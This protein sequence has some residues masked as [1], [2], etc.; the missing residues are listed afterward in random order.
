[1][2]QTLGGYKIF[3]SNEDTT[4]SD[5][6]IDKSLILHR[7]T[8]ADADYERYTA[9]GYFKDGEFIWIP[10]CCGDGGSGQ[11]C[12]ISVSGIASGQAT[13]G[14]NDVNLRVFVNGLKGAPTFTINGVQVSP[15]STSGNE[16]IFEG[17]GQG[18][19]TVIVTDL[20]ITEYTCTG[21]TIIN[22]T[23]EV[24]RCDGF[25]LTLT[26][27]NAGGEA[28]PVECGLTGLRVVSVNDE[29]DPIAYGTATGQ[30]LLDVE[31]TWTGPLLFTINGSASIQPTP[32]SAGSSI[33][34]YSNLEAGEYTVFV[35]DTAVPNSQCLQSVYFEIVE[36]EDPCDGFNLTLTKQDSGAYPDLTCD[37]FNV[38]LTKQDTGAYEPCSTFSLTTTSQ[39]S[40]TSPITEATTCQDFFINLQ[41]VNG[42]IL[43]TLNDGNWGDLEISYTTSNPLDSSA[44]WTNIE[45]IADNESGIYNLGNLNEGRNYIRVIESTRG[46]IDIEVIDLP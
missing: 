7:I 30:V 43:M 19:Y 37:G 35:V 2:E 28:D 15:D 40:G 8:P 27:Q 29:S 17:Y 41:A 12:T 20:G 33:Y 44:I 3:G 11:L 36:E 6:D 25:T 1:M 46:C 39:Y 31:G 22:V 26:A 34:R 42:E 4:L 5:E 16:Y 14:L 10:E 18:T 13:Q 9:G 38:T 21:S 24:D 23:E 45:N 32:I